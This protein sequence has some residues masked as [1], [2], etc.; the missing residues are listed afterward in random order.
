MQL[1]AQAD[2]RHAEL[3]LWAGLAIAA[4]CVPVAWLMYRFVELP[5]QRVPLLTKARP[6]RSLLAAGVASVVVVAASATGILALRVVPLTTD[7]TV[8]SVEAG[9][10]APSFTEFVPE[11]IS[12]TL[13]GAADDNPE[14][15]ANGCHLD[16]GD[17]V[18]P[19][20]CTFGAVAA[21]PL[22]ALF[23]DSHAAQWY[24]PL[25]ALADSGSIRLVTYTKSACPSAVVE[26]TLDGLPYATCTQWR[27]AV[28]DE[29]G[30][31]DVDAIIVA[32]SH[33][34]FAVD[35]WKSGL[36][37]LFADL[38]EDVDVIQMADTPRF[39]FGP[40]GCLSANVTDALACSVPRE[41]ALDEKFAD[42][43]REAAEAG[44]ATYADL[45]DHLCSDVC[46][47]VIGSNLVYRDNDHLGETFS[48]ELAP[49]LGDA[50][51]SV[52]EPSEP[53]AGE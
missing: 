20:D 25:R 48:A 1:P 53:P 7:M 16:F 44:D 46:G 49:P 33:E 18:L 29:L 17:V 26:T 39:P 42:A 52:V 8:A 23:G 11:N 15:Y 36:E 14:I 45:N 37:D 34:G 31:S 4:L 27:E 32:N 10:A 6:R 35:E 13:A 3:P 28:L 19:D 5:A 50:V 22:I 47:T 38:P 40:A 30:A 21:A 51:L 24:P 9:I 41:E 2:G 43:E 12:P